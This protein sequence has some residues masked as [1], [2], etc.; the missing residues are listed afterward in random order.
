MIFCLPVSLYSCFGR[1]F[2][3]CQLCHESPASSLNLSFAR[4]VFLA[5]SAS[6]SRTGEWKVWQRGAAQDAEAG[7]GRHEHHERVG[8]HAALVLLRFQALLELKIRRLVGASAGDVELDR[9]K[10]CSQLHL[11]PS[12]VH[13]A[14]SICAHAA[15]HVFFLGA[16]LLFNEQQHI[17]GDGLTANCTVHCVFECPRPSRLGLSRA[18]ICFP[19]GRRLLRSRGFLNMERTLTTSTRPATPRWRGRAEAECTR[20]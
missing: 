16:I 1:E 7:R 18:W 19:L 17:Q 4:L 11:S 20:R 6:N 8:P 13:S 5:A 2:A 9:P 14:N 3:G 15:A 12:V 10:R